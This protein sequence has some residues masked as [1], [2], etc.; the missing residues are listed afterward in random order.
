MTRTTQILLVR[1]ALEIL[2]GFES[3]K[4]ILVTPG[5]VELGVIEKEENHNL[6]LQASAFATL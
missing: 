3:G 1:Y 2:G 6:G 4:K 5:M